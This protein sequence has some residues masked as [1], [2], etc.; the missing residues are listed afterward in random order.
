MPGDLEASAAGGVVRQ[1]R[2]KQ[3]WIQNI[4]YEQSAA[5]PARAARIF[6]LDGIM[7]KT[8]LKGAR[9]VPMTNL[10]G[11]DWQREGSSGA[12]R[13]PGAGQNTIGFHTPFFKMNKKGR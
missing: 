13:H 5:R 12:A 1:C 9:I 8:S 10:K 7:K 4:S 2:P 11:I 3:I 6:L